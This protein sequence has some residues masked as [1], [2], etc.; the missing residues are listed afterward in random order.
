MSKCIPNEQK[1]KNTSPCIF[2]YFSHLKHSINGYKG[3]YN[4]NDTLYAEAHG[5][6]KN[7]QIET[8]SA[9]QS[10]NLVFTGKRLLIFSQ[11]T[12]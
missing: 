4:F 6:K 5:M 3:S 1:S 2:V 11:M 7:A 9:P 10:K 8:T 12:T